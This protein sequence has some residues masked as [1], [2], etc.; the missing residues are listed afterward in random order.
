MK[1]NT[2]LVVKYTKDSIN[3]KKFKLIVI[4]NFLNFLTGN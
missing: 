1:K 2:L 4:G 3:T